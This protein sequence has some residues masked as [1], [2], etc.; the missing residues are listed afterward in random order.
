MIVV[1]IIVE[2]VIVVVEIAVMLFINNSS[3]VFNVS[4]RF[5]GNYSNGNIRYGSSNID[6]NVIRYVVVVEW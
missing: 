5:G 1:I 4:E 2:V 3:N 6:R